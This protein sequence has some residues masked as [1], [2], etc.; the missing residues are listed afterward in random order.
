MKVDTGRARAGWYASAQ[1]LGKSLDFSSGI[2]GDNK[3]SEGKKKGSYKEK[4]SG[5]SNKYIEMINGVSYIIYLEYGW[6]KQA[7]T[8][9]VRISMRQMRGKLAKNYLSPEF[10]ANWNK[11]F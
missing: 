6:S 9:M 8:G 11:Y 5:F 2:K 10:K 1:G 3:V 7:P 4:L